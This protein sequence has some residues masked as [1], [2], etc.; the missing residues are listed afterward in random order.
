MS[1][2]YE[3]YQSKFTYTEDECLLFMSLI[4]LPEK[5]VFT[6][7]N[8]EDTIVISNLI[9]YIIKTKEFILKEYKEYK[10]E[11]KDEFNK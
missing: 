9:E 5:I 1:S 4:S 7:N 6:K 8:Y 11:N 2:L 3:I 10:K